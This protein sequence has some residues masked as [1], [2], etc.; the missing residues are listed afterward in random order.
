MAWGAGLV[1]GY[2]SIRQPEALPG[3]W[4]VEQSRRACAQAQATGG[5]CAGSYRC[6]GA[7]AVAT[8]K[9][10]TVAYLS[11]TDGDR[12]TMHSG[13]ACLSCL[14]LVKIDEQ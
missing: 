2:G 1:A 10:H 4:S 14:Q 5:A 6:S 8:L 13:C 9:I 11:D 7:K 3:W 12:L